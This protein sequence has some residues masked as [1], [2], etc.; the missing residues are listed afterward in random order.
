MADL[1]EALTK[2]IINLETFG[3]LYE[4]CGGQTSYICGLESLTN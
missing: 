2:G 1:V 3:K 4:F